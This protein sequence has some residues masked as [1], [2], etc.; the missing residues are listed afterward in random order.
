M[1]VVIVVVGTKIARSCVVG[2][3]ARCKITQSVDNWFVCA[4]NCSKRLTRAITRAFSVQ[5]ACGLSTTPTLACA[6]TTAHAQAQSWKGSSVH[7]TAL[8]AIK[9]YATVVTGHA[10]YVFYRALVLYELLIM[11]AFFHKVVFFFF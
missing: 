8:H 9:Y 4:L 10:G 6:D 1:S 11:V 3:Y 7:K 2:F 5:H